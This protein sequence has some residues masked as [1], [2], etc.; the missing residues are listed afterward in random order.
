LSP[1][2][3][4]KC[5]KNFKMD[6]TKNLMNLKGF[7]YCDH[8]NENLNE[9]KGKIKIRNLNQEIYIDEKNI[10]LRVS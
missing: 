2:L 9:F 7:I 4:Q 1:K 8:P 6:K 3:K 10:L 5:Y